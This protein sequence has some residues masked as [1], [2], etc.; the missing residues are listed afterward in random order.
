MHGS[1]LNCTCAVLEYLHIHKHS[2]RL[3]GFVNL[4]EI[5]NYLLQFEQSLNDEKA[6]PV[7]AN[8]V[9]AFMVKGLFTNLRFLMLSFHHW[10][11]NF[12]SILANSF[13]LERISFKVHF[14]DKIIIYLQY[15]LHVCVGY[16]L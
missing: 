11:T 14:H 12:F 16:Y 9:I 1:I 2:G 4:G 10:G 15:Y 3:G 8:S 7:L 5:N 6:E 13:S